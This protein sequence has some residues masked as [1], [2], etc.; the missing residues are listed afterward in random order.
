MIVHMNIRGIQAG[1]EPGTMTSKRRGPEPESG[2]GTTRKPVHNSVELV[3]HQPAIYFSSSLS[4][5]N[6]SPT[7]LNSHHTGRPIPRPTV[8]TAVRIIRGQSGI[9]WLTDIGTSPV[10]GVRAGTPPSPDLQINAIR[11]A[12]KKIRDHAS[13]RAGIAR[14]SHIFQYGGVEV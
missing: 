11:P 8:N 9:K 1:T 2:L 14:K 7:F 10:E 4:L 5:L 12:Q 6:S 3:C 13:Q